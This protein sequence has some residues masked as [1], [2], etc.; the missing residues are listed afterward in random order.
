MGRKLVG[1][2]G[3]IVPGAAKGVS[4]VSGSVLAG[5]SVRAGPIQHQPNPLLADV[6]REGVEEGAE[7][8]DVSRGIS[9]Q[10]SEPA[11]LVAI[12]QDPAR[13]DPVET[14]AALEQD[15]QREAPLIDRPGRRGELGAFARPWSLLDVTA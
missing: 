7:A 3:K 5:W 15:L 12:L 1:N 14:P 8:G 11:S 2:V 4:T 13:S 9:A 6:V 10:K